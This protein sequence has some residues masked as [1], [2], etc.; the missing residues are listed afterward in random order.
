MG[1]VRT[2]RSNALERLAE[3]PRAIRNTEQCKR[4][5]NDSDSAVNFAKKNHE[6]ADAFFSSVLRSPRRATH[7]IN[8]H[9]HVGDEAESDRW[10]QLLKRA[11][12][13]E[14]EVQQ[15]PDHQRMI[16]GRLLERLLVDEP[17]RCESENTQR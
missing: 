9:N 2:H 8:C 3:G 15:E 12:G 11:A 17:R 10:P 4:M 16:V 6:D 7:G 13:R 5:A 14:I 1:N